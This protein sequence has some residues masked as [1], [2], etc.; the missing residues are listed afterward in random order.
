[1]SPLAELIL[2][3]CEAQADEPSTDPDIDEVEAVFLMMRSPIHVRTRQQMLAE[4]EK[5]TAKEP[6]PKLA[7]RR[8]LLEW[9]ATSSDG[10]DD[11]QPIVVEEPTSG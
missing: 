1:M 10:P 2:R 4:L 6:D 8:R 3:R 5:A 7:A 11:E 9:I